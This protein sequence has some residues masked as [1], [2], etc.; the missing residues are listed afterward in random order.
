MDFFYPPASFYQVPFLVCWAILKPVFKTVP[1]VVFH[2]VLPIAMALFITLLCI[3]LICGISESI[4]GWP[5][6]S[7]PRTH[8]KKTGDRKAEDKKSRHQNDIWAHVEG[9]DATE[10]RILVRDGDLNEKKRLESELESLAAMAR[11]R[12][13]RLETLDKLLKSDAP[14]VW[15]EV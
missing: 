9:Q 15:E 8:A 12:M 4:F 1:T 13:E 6:M 14:L 3:V 5:D 11:S 2:I 7:P 10:F